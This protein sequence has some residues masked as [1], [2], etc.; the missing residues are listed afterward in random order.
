MGISVRGSIP[1]CMMHKTQH[2]LNRPE[3]ASI[4]VCCASLFISYLSLTQIT[5]FGLKTEQTCLAVPK[6]EYPGWS[7]GCLYYSAWPLCFQSCQL[8][9]KAECSRSTLTSE[10]VFQ[11]AYS[12]FVLHC[13][14]S[15]HICAGEARSALAASGSPLAERYTH[16]HSMLMLQA[17]NGISTSL[18]YKRHINCFLQVKS[19]QHWQHRERLLQSARTTSTACSCSQSSCHT[20]F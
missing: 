11:K 5:Q 8:A 13:V 3:P 18:H 7:Q 14:A 10:Y 6:A 4:D 19:S 16:K 17:S 12:L 15:L 1:S 20:A 9:N 2:S